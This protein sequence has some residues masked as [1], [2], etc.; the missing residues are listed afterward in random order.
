[1][2]YTA[3]P[4]FSSQEYLYT[5][6]SSVSGATSTHGSR[7]LRRRAC[8]QHRSSSP[9]RPPRGR[10]SLASHQRAAAR[11]VW[12]P[13]LRTSPSSRSWAKGA[14]DAPF[15]AG[16]SSGQPKHSGEQFELKVLVSLTWGAGNLS[17]Y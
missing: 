9:Q 8:S 5:Y 16:I 10:C 7:P 15:A 12:P 11:G 4:T 1:M 6:L 17:G 14:R 13:W 3:L 2:R